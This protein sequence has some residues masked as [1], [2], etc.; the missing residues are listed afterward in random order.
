MSMWRNGFEL[1]DEVRR[2]ARALWGTQDGDDSA[3][4]IDGRERDCIFETEELTH[5]IEC[6]RKRELAKV[7]D[8]AKK[9][10][11]YREMQAKHGQLVKL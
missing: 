9:M 4:M 2:I 3:Q 8:D 1:E 6:T 10:V 7:R 11:K 5:Y